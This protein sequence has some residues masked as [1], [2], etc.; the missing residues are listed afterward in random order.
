[1]FNIQKYQARRLNMT[2]VLLIPHANPDL[3]YAWRKCW[4]NGIINNCNTSW[5]ITSYI[6]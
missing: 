2:I 5:K 3:I 6:S 4:L 1:M